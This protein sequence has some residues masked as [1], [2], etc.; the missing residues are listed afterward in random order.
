MIEHHLAEHVEIAVEELRH[1]FRRDRVAHLGEAFE[2][3]EQHE[4]RALLA[5]EAQQFGLVDDRLGNVARD[6]LAERTGGEIALHRARSARGH[7]DGGIDQDPSDQPA[8]HRQSVGVDIANLQQH[9]GALKDQQLRHAKQRKLSRRPFEQR[10]QRRD[11]HHQRRHRPQHPCRDRL[12]N[13]VIEHLGDDLGMDGDPGGHLAV[14]RG[15]RRLDPVIVD[16][17][18]ADQDILAGILLLEEG[19]DLRIGI[20]KQVDL[21]GREKHRILILGPPVVDR[22]LVIGKGRRRLASIG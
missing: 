14:D 5:A 6:I 2:I 7:R 12:E 16:D 15:E 8:D 20:D 4:D 1:H 3:A 19:Q 21:G 11:Q 9:R 18:A 17:I 22:A 10:G 13:P